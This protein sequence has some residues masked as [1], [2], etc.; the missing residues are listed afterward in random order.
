MASDKC[1]RNITVTSG[2]EFTRKLGI[3][4]WEM[5]ALKNCEYVFREQRERKFH[6]IEWHFGWNIFLRAFFCRIKCGW[7][8]DEESCTRSR[9]VSWENFILTFARNHRVRFIWLFF[10]YF[11][12]SPP[13]WT[14]LQ[15]LFRFSQFSV[16]RFKNTVQVPHTQPSLISGLNLSWSRQWKVVHCLFLH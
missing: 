8:T 1:M 7:R 4:H 9:C 5:F 15:I 10:Q 6:K 16:K 13:A 2:N 12:K 11:Y 14:V 3:R